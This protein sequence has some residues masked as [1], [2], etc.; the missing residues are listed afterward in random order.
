[1]NAIG[2]R[3][4]ERLIPIVP[5]GVRREENEWQEVNLL[6]DTGFNGDLCLEAPL[7]DRHCLAT[8]PPRQLVTP[9]EA[10]ERYDCRGPNAP[11]ELEVLWKRFPR[12]A[13]LRLMREYAEDRPFCGMLG[14]GLLRYHMVTVDVVE[15]GTV[16]VD[17]VHSS[18]ER[19]GPRW[20]PG[21]NKHPR[22]STENLEEYLEWFSEHL[23]WTNLP[24][25]DSA[26]RWR[27]VWVN[28]DTGDNGELTL[29][30]SWVA[31]LGLKLPET[32]TI[33]TPNGSESV[34]QGDGKVKWQGRERWVKCQHRE[35]VPPLIGMKLLQ[36]NRVTMDFTCPRPAAEIRQIPGPARS[37]R[38]LFDPL[39]DFFRFDRG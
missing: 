16:T 27:S 35:G 33:Q 32:S 21:K 31:K 34:N 13:S 30:T 20:R 39:A 4:N 23:P 29:P 25:Q 38:G 8:R 17:D 10:L 36:G 2:G 5:V 9:D 37:K 7:L 3:V 18:T 19:R 11:Y 22:P 12:D 1:M 14:T 6:L 15:G 24:V 28:V 26:G